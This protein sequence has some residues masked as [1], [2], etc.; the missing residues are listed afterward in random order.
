MVF[1]LIAM[2]PRSIYILLIIL[3]VSC[4]NAVFNVKK[5]K[6]FFYAHIAVYL[7]LNFAI[8]VPY[9]LGVTRCRVWKIRYMLAWSTYRIFQ[10]LVI[11]MYD[12]KQ[13]VIFTINSVKHAFTYGNI[14]LCL[15]GSKVFQKCEIELKGKYP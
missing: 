14:M 1:L 9:N 2:I 13:V 10:N 8:D 7:A 12:I 11:Y 6:K 4:K 5:G 15:W 3:Y